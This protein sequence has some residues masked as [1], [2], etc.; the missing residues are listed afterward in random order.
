VPVKDRAPTDLGGGRRSRA[1]HRDQL[2]QEEGDAVRG[3]TDRSA[4]L[5]R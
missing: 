5:A 4:T 3:G 2:L 1:E